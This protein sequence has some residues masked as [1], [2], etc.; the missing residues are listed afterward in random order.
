[1]AISTNNDVFL[2]D[3]TSGVEENLTAAN[4]GNDCNPVF[5]PK[6]RYLAYFS[7]RR[8]VYEADKKD[9]ILFD[10]ISKTR[11]NL[12]QD[13]ANTILEFVFAPDEKFIYF[14]AP[15]QI[16]QPVYQLELKSGKIIR[17]VEKVN[18]SSLSIMPDGKA[19]IF[20]S[21]SV[22]RPN[23]IHKL[24]LR[25]RALTRLTDVNGEI[26]RDVEMNGAETFTFKGAKN[27]AVEGI[28][29]KPPFFDPAQKYPLVFLVH[30]GPQGA[31]SDDFHFRWNLSMF[32]APGY[33][34]AAINFHGSHGYGQPFTDA[35]TQD[36]G[37]A[38]FQDLVKGQQ[39]L[40]ENFP[41]LDAKR[42]AAAGASYGGFM[43][44]W[45]AGHSDDFKYPFRC[46]ISH[47]GIFDARSMYYMTEELWFEEWE[48][49]GTPWKSPLYEKWNP[50]NFASR[51]NVPMLVVHSENDF[52][53]PVSQGIMLFTA[54]QRL[55]VKSK[56][57]YF[58]D[59]DHFVQKPQNAKLWWK[60]VYDWIAENIK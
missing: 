23:E 58:P 57:L 11:R 22:S 28:L 37:G 21:Q 8:A 45:M 10:R 54:L 1:M 27:E 13:F 49:G 3:L 33:V 50:A 25:D 29:L 51:I 60:T 44:N 9:I 32:A 56:M 55:G 43:I 42:I 4:G 19:L 17:L 46:L 48:Y 6:N 35:V 7:M 53:V 47:D 24:S 26:F 40:V 34:V 15:E 30:G 18:A 16:Y 39:Y 5:S 14:I 20:L 2:K 59:E 41:F 38:P 36:W 31:W 52:R 12:T